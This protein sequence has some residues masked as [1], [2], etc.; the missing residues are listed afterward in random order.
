MREYRTREEAENDPELNLMIVWECD[1]CGD[2]RTDY[3]NFNVGGLCSC[4]GN[5]QQVGESYNC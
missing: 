5:W 4:G 2:E 3:P 1:K